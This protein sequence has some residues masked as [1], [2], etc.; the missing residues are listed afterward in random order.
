MDLFWDAR[1]S[2]SNSSTDCLSISF[3]LHVIYTYMYLHAQT[4]RHTIT[5]NRP[6]AMYMSTR[7][8]VCVQGTYSILHMSRFASE[9]N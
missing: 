1:S 5:I 9:T 2:L 7:V 6:G 8:C 4:H 3:L